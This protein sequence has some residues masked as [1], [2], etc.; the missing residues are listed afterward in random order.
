[1]AAVSWP[2]DFSWFVVGGLS[3]V[4]EVE[5]MDGMGAKHSKVRWKKV[6]V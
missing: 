4:W 6:V 1:M 3:T 5:R 2:T